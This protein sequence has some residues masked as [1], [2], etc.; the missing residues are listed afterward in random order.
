MAPAE[1][2]KVLLKQSI[3]TD[4]KTTK[5]TSKKTEEMATEGRGSS[6]ADSREYERAVEKVN[7]KGE[8][9]NKRISNITSIHNND[10]SRNNNNNLMERACSE[11][12]G[13]RR[14]PK[15]FCVTHNFPSFLLFFFNI[16]S[17][18][19]LQPG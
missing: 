17:R 7:S 2:K 3:G 11:D 15:V 4:K 18:K 1:R 19:R 12:R 16:S 6:L 10:S 13:L 8:M 14:R 9:K 5:K